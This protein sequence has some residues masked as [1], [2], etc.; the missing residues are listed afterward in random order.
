MHP[1]LLA[2]VDEI[3]DAPPDS[4]TVVIPSKGREAALGAL[5]QYYANAG[6]KCRILVLESGNRYRALIDRYPS[7]DIELI[8]F[9]E[10][11]SIQDKLQEGLASVHT[12]LVAMCTD[13][14]IAIHDGLK[15]AGGFLVQHCI[16]PR[17]IEK[18]L[19]V[20]YPL[21]MS[22]PSGWKP[23]IKIRSWV[24]RP[25]KKVSPM[26]DPSHGRK[27]RQTPSTS[28]CRRG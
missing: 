28:I 27:P 24:S 9:H 15:K 3:A 5:L 25:F 16:V 23:C 20:G 22:W 18:G 4:L 1:A 11:T 6:L 12:P 26:R 14:D 2:Q 21:M 13:D 17:R 19:Y 7:L 10:Q 8:E